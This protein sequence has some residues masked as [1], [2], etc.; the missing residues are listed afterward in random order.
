MNFMIEPFNF[1]GDNVNN[2]TLILPLLS[3]YQPRQFNPLL[4]RDFT[5]SVKTHLTQSATK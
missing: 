2:L 3:P 5:S 4:L 1:L